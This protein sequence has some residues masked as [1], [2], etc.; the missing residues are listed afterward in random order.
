M[1]WS[2]LSSLI[3]LSLFLG[4]FTFASTLI[5]GNKYEGTVSFIDLENGKE[6]KRTETGGSPHELILSPDK[7][8]VVVVSYLEDGYVGEE[9]NV[10]DVATGKRLSIIDISPHMGPHGIAWL[11][12]GDDLIVTTEET[13]DVIKVDT[14]AGKVLGSVSTDQIGSHLLALSPD[15]KT[16]YVTSRGSDTFSVIDTDTM[17]LKKTLPAGDGPEAVWVSPDGKELWIGNNRSKN[18]FIFDTA[19]LKKKDVIDV[20]Y[21]PIRI[22]F[23]PEGKLVAVADLQGNR[24]VI[25]DAATR[26]ELKSIDLGAASA[27]EPASLLFTPDGKFL[28]AGSQRDGK[29]VEI[30]TDKWEIKRIFKAGQGAD[31]LE[32]SPVT[33]QP[34]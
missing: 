6:I 30:D 4:S 32:W 33:I 27:R 31:G 11:G 16:A 22:S 9:L 5:V 10:F 28:Y 3:L 26:K 12:S 15:T 7:S 13:H 18:I 20:G 1:R 14:V 24:V 34:E 23:H 21:L 25:Y 8:K 19:S 29:V 17:T 2:I